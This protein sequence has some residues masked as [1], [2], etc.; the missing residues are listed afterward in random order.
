M[1]DTET[2]YLAPLLGSR[3]ASDSGWKAK[4][5]HFVFS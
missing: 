3:G 4:A 1:L 2:A 5:M